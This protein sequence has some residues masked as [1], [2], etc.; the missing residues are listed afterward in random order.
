MLVKRQPLRVLGDLPGN[1][2]ICTVHAAHRQLDTAKV[3]RYIV[4]C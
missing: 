2:S 4:A 3:Q 1:P